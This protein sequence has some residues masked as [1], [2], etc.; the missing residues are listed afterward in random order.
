M[1][2]NA[3]TI[4]SC[5][6]A[7]VLQGGG[8]E[9]LMASIGPH[10]VELICAMAEIRRCL[11]ASEAVALANDLISGTDTEIQIIEWKRARMN[12]TTIHLCWDGN[13]GNHSRK[14]GHIG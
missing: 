2:I 8:A 3:A 1:K 7:N 6:G 12:T 5:K 4:R 9:T 14:D 11:T 13:G 10:L